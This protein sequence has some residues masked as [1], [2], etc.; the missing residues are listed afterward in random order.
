MHA[1]LY[2][3]VG[4]KEKKKL[5]DKS[6]LESSTDTRM[7]VLKHSIITSLLWLKGKKSDWFSRR[8][9]IPSPHSLCLPFQMYIFV[10]TY[11]AKI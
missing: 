7:D 6:I 4:R 11:D 8:R 1:V 2:T 3:H 5:S 10:T 9:L